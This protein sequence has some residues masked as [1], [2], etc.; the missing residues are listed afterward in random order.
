[1]KPVVLIV[2]QA[3]QKTGLA[4]VARGMAA[5]LAAH[6]EMH[7]L[8]IDCFDAQPAEIMPGGWTLH[9][10]SRR[11]DMF[12][13]MRLRELVDA[14]QPDHV[15]LYNDLGV[16]ERYFD[17]L[18]QAA[19]RCAVIGYCPV[20]GNIIHAEAVAAL[21]RLDALV[22]FTNFARAAMQ[23]AAARVGLGEHAVFRQTHVIAHGL[24][25]DDFHP[26]PVAEA[27][28]DRRRR[29]ARRA[30]FPQQAALWEGFWVLNANRNQPRKRLDLTL[31]GFARFVAGKPADVRLYLHTGM[32]GIGI[33]ILSCAATLGITERLL[34]SRRDGL[35]PDADTSR[36]NLIYNACDVGV[37]TAIGEG[38]G[39]VSCEHA[40]T[41]AAQIVP[42]HSACAELWR[43]AAALL[44]PVQAVCAGLLDGG[45]IDPAELAQQLQYLYDDDIHRQR[46]A[47]AAHARVTAPAYGW[48]Q[49][50]A[51]W[52]G[53]F[54]EVQLGKQAAAR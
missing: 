39:L 6:C 34:L 28:D 31:E 17:R 11:Y 22:V 1:M 7:V 42:R 26:W 35:H 43:D 48:S 3:A 23:D 18:D 25:M 52:R 36:L 29:A 16:I 19:H 20:D 38:W 54:D 50:A 2:S 53:L 8:G 49:V 32:Q 21:V 37:N 46:M 10:N 30:L 4:R 44:E 47:A 24:E 27:D 9:G 14:L 5:Q 40:A 12:A 33:D 15:I 13:E 51:Q 45:V 41:R